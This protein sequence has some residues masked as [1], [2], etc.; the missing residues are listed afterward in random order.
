MT[1]LDQDLD[2]LLREIA[3]RPAETRARL[4]PRLGRLIET[5]QQ[6][7]RTVPAEARRVNEE[8]LCEAI[9]AQFDNMP[10]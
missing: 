2:R 4:R 3:A 7:G 6:E 1:T 8:L 5:M 9:E 10:V